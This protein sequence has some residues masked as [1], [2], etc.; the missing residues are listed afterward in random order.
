ML[1]LDL[2]L[3]QGSVRRLKA[4]ADLINLFGA[5]M[6]LAQVRFKARDYKNSIALYTASLQVASERMPWEAAAIFKD[7]MS[8]VLC[9]RSAAF[10]ACGEVGP[11]PSSRPSASFPSNRCHAPVESALH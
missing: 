6:R 9:N 11:R 3:V 8:T 7:E 2:S 5:V 1:A 10:G 4:A